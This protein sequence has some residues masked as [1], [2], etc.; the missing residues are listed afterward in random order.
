MY[1]IWVAEDSQSDVFL[2]EEALR[3]HCVPCKLYIVGDGAKLIDLLDKARKEVGTPCP[4]L[5]I[6][7]WNLPLGDG[8]RTL[9]QVAIHAACLEV[10][11][12]VLTSSSS[13]KDREEALRCGAR[14]YLKKPND[15][16]EFLAIGGI[17]R[18]MLGEPPHYSA[19]AG[20]G[21]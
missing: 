16:D 9:E 8:P 21:R 12:L 17:I 4:N 18:Q 2:L 5:V 11:V 1:E 14:E 13:V 6:L 15:L 7:D 3:E 10:P 20:G 19:S